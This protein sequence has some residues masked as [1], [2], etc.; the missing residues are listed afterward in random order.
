MIK[1]EEKVLI[2]SEKFDVKKLFRVFV[3][4]GLAL[5][6]LNSVLLISSDMSYYNEEYGE[7]H[8]HNSWC[9]ENHD[10]YYYDKYDDGDGV[11][12]NEDKMDCYQVVYGNA[13]AYGMGM[14]FKWY[15]LTT[16]I[17]LVAFWIFTVGSAI[18]NKSSEPVNALNDLPF[19][20]R[21]VYLHITPELTDVSVNAVDLT[22]LFKHFQD[23]HL[24]FVY[25]AR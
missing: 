13:F 8:V 18:Y 11:L 1:M 15:I 3:I 20:A 2:Q 21:T 9:Y 4:I 5:T 7:N 12:S 14:F 25:S 23:D 6:L 24:P 10:D 19:T 16:L 17:P 22:T